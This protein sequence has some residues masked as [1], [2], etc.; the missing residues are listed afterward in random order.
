MILKRKKLKVGNIFF[1]SLESL[2]SFYN[3][4]TPKKDTA[5]SE[6][7][8]LFIE[9]D[10]FLKLSEID[11]ELLPV[12][13]QEEPNVE[14]QVEQISDESELF[15]LKRTIIDLEQELKSSSRQ[16]TSLQEEISTLI[17]EK[18]Q[19]EKPTGLRGF[20]LHEDLHLWGQMVVAVVLMFFTTITFH[21]YFDFGNVYNFIHWILCIMAGLCFEFSLLVFAA[22]KQMNWLNFGLTMQ[23]II[24]GVHSGLFES[25][26]GIGFNDFLIKI[27][28]T[29]LLPL[30]GKAFGNFEI[31]NK[32]DDKNRI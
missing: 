32:K 23:F 18:K 28:L 24:L 5:K 2:I 13:I 20:L 31:I 7:H 17:K 12:L 25:Y 4:T 22:R 8:D 11:N 14:T 9:C 16:N 19:S 1:F 6:T 10:G 21:K 26:L 29:M 15:S 27:V 3:S 30:M